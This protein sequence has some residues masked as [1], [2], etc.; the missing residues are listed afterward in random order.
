MIKVNIV[1]RVYPTENKDKVLRAIKN[2]ANI[3]LGTL[4]IFSGKSYNIIKISGDNK[5][6]GRFRSK[7]FRRGIGEV[8]KIFA[9]KNTRENKTYLFLNKQAAYAGV[10]NLVENPDESPLGSIKIE[11]EANNDHELSNFITYLTRL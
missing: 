9:G 11:I 7:I 8:I 10:V 5:L 3:E 1:T 4:Q 6:L 2:I